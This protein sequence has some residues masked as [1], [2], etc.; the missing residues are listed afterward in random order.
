MNTFKNNQNLTD[1]I[2]YIN[3]IR[4]RTLVK[5]I[6]NNNS[7]GNI[8]SHTSCNTNFCCSIKYI[9][10]HNNLIDMKKAFNLVVNKNLLTQNAYPYQNMCFHNT[11]NTHGLDPLGNNFPKNYKQLFNFCKK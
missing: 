6:Q 9:N 4:Q 8:Y 1:S 10:S 7:S 11:N 2:D 3:K 5:N